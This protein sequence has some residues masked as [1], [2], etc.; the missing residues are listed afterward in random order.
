M[1]FQFPYTER[2]RQMVEHP[3]QI[4]WI[5]AGTK[6]GKSAGLFCW[7]I[8]G[9]LHGE[10]CCFCGPW[11]FRSRRAFDEIKN[12]LEPWIVRRQ[13][14]VNE[15]RL[16]LSAMGGGYLD[17]TSAD[18]PHGVFGSNYSRVVLDEASRSL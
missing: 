18:N 11:F 6:T 2:Q 17:F 8:Q 5:G 16:Q 9:L 4:L 3:A 13:V 12:L 7:L 1:K 10:A 14:K 15:A